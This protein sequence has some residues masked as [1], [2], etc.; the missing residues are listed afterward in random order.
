[1]VVVA[2]KFYLAEQQEN[3]Y[4]VHRMCYGAGGS[5]M[6]SDVFCK[7]YNEFGW[8]YYPE[9]FGQQLLQW[10]KQENLQPQTA[11]DLACGTGVLCQILS[12]SGM[13]VWG[14]DFSS[15]MIDIARQGRGSIHY[16]VADM[17]TYRPEKQFDLVTCTGDAINHIPNLG[18]VEKIFQNVYAYLSPGGYFVFDILN[19]HE[20]SDSEPFEMDFTDTV[21]VWFQMTRPGEKQVNL[22]IRVYEDGTLSFE[23]NIRETVHDP[24]AICQLLQRCGF[25]VEKCAD[26]LLSDGSHGTTWFVIAHKG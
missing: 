15:G 16:D 8:N 9:I 11:L 20:V 4:N 22:K 7:V 26:S 5:G 18:D 23:E 19:E 24:A 25:T 1:M 2:S 14:M 21:R 17:T 10:L 3:R 6:Y 13:E 12:D